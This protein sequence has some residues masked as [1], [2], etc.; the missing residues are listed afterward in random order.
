MHKQWAWQTLTWGAHT[1]TD[2]APRPTSSQPSPPS[3]NNLPTV[4]PVSKEI[5]MSQDSSA[6]SMLYCLII[7]RNFMLNYLSHEGRF[8][9]SSASL[10]W[11]GHSMC[12][13]ICCSTHRNAHMMLGFTE[14]STFVGKGQRMLA[15]RRASLRLQTK[16]S[17][18]DSAFTA[19]AEAPW[20]GMEGKVNCKSKGTLW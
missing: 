20:H 8:P 11:P 14:L 15:C 12:K 19:S 17:C 3:K 16:G 4:W 2:P 18:G 1:S 7:N 10:S 5:V 13:P 9:I 6:G